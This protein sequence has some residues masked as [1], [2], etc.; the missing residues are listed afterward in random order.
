MAGARAALAAEADGRTFDGVWAAARAE[1]RR[2]LSRIEV[3]GGTPAQDSTF[4]TALD[5][6]LLQPNAWSDV[7][8]RDRGRDGEVHRAEG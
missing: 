7:D 5:H 1:W 8:G 4:M 3:V 6:T 2:A